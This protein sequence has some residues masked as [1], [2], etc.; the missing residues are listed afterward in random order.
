MKKTIINYKLFTA[1]ALSITLLGCAAAKTALN[2]REL[3]VESKTSYSVVLEPVAASKRVVYAKV[4]DL[5]GN[6]M[7][8]DMQ[9][10]LERILTEEGLTLTKDPDKANLMITGSIIAA[11]KGSAKDANKYLNSGYK[12]G[13]EG[14]FALGSIAALSGNDGNTTAGAALVGAG[15]GFLADALVEDVYFT[16]VMD[17]QLRERP[18]KGDSIQNKTKNGSSKGLAGNN[19]KMST[20]NSSSVS[21]GE[22]YNWIVY[23]TRVV[24]TANKMNLKIEEAIPEVQRKAAETISEMML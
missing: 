17:V 7:R 8:K 5:S 13:V 9:S 24:S 22:N 15:A 21:R 1:L 11:E 10:Q 16:F 6:S 19:A 20:K 14:A 23:E 18:L 12:S 4:R 3:S 2:K